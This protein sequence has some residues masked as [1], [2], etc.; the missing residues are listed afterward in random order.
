MDTETIKE[1]AARTAP[2]L[3]GVTWLVLDARLPQV[4]SPDGAHWLTDVQGR[5]TERGTEMLAYRQQVAD[6]LDHADLVCLQ[7]SMVVPWVDFGGKRQALGLVD[8]KGKQ[9]V[10][11]AEIVRILT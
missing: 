4:V 1:W 2:K 8:Y 11:G 6:G 3:P 10:F 5:L 9:T 7:L